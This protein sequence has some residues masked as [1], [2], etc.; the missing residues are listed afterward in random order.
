[1]AI[2]YCARARARANASGGTPCSTLRSAAVRVVSRRSRRSTKRSGRLMRTPSHFW[3]SKSAAMSS[4]SCGASLSA[5]ARTRTASSA[6]CT[7]EDAI[8]TL[9]IDVE[10]TRGPYSSAASAS[11]ASRVSKSRPGSSSSSSGHRSPSVSSGK[12][13]NVSGARSRIWRTTCHRSDQPS[14]PRRSVGQTMG[15][16][17]PGGGG[18][19]ASATAELTRSASSERSMLHPSSLGWLSRRAKSR[20]VGDAVGRRDGFA[21]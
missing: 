10:T 4:S 16:L 19:F 20:T 15:L 5:N 18:A 2:A 11:R 7:A 12:R 3:T 6:S 21:R 9:Q 17:P 13:T 8:T 14:S 1:M